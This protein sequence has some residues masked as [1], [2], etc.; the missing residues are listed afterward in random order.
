M[1]YYRQEKRHN[2]ANPS[3]TQATH[4]ARDTNPKVGEEDDH[5]N[6]KAAPHSNLLTYSQ[7]AHWKHTFC[8][9]CSSCIYPARAPLDARLLPVLLRPAWGFDCNA[10]TVLASFRK[11]VKQTACNGKAFFP[12]LWETT[13]TAND[14][15]GDGTSSLLGGRTHFVA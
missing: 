14:C 12:S 4:H 9:C 10:N 7:H 11:I 2:G 15:A 5:T 13:G 1:R 6:K 8:C 3:A